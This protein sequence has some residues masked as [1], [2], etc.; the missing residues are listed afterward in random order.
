[1]P[2]DAAAAVLQQ[3]QS[4]TA[5]NTANGTQTITISSIDIT[6]SFLVFQVR[7]S[8]DRPV[9]TTLRGRL[10]SATTIQ[11]ERSTNEGAP[12]AINI[13]WYVATFGSGVL[14]QR[15]TATMSALTVNVPVTA[16]ASMSQAFVLWS[17]TP[18]TTEL[19]HG[20][21]DVIAGDL[22]TTTNLQFR[23][24]DASGHIV[25]WQVVEF[26]DP[27]DINVQ[28]GTVSTMTGAT[29]TATATL[30]TAVDVSR[31]FVLTGLRTVGLGPDIGARMLR[32]QLTG[33][34]TIAFDRGIAG[35]PDDM[36][37]ISWQAVELRDGSTVQ[38]GSASFAAGVA[39]A[40]ATLVTRVNT[41][42]AI[43]FA[44]VQAGGQS[45][46][47]TP[48]AGNDAHGS[49]LDHGGALADATHARS[50]QHRGHRRRRLVRRAV[51]RRR[52][53]QDRQLHE[54]ARRCAHVADDRPRPRRGAQGAHPL[55]AGPIRRDVQQR[56]RHHVSRRGDGN[57]RRPAI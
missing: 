46:G 42:R 24:N 27:A 30:G 26:T 12:L 38:R 49:R 21:D 44:S 55:D 43:A 50:Q 11:F 57:C 8:G 31:T 18:N 47:R 36:N 40:T 39:Q 2:Q 6:K 52:R 14:V 34:T 1:M 3:V 15:G 54:G 10:A 45:M 9:S 4:G 29:L 19:E 28:R 32:A 20:S 16:V 13:Q 53:V 7:S 23:T 17:M 48:Y 41:T 56:V 35:S 5:V 22:T 51:R 37:E 25:W 33:P